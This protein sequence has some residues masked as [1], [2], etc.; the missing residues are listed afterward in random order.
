MVQ[1][2][3]IRAASNCGSTAT[4]YSGFLDALGAGGQGMGQTF[5]G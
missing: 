1:A 4:H 5:W 2:Q 3:Q